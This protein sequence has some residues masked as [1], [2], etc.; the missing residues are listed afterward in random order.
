MIKYYE[1]ALLRSSAPLL[2]Y[3]FDNNIDI[4]SIVKVSLK[5]PNIKDAV[6]LQEVEKP[7]FKTENI[8]EIRKIFFK[9]WQMD[10]A[11]FIKSYYFSSF[12]EA[13]SLFTPFRQNIEKKKI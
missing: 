12:G 7:K 4:G 8:L 3:S 5:Q 10:V 2:T 9:S 11:K 6:I 1:V 13:I